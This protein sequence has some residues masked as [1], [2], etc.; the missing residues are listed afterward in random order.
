[1]LSLDPA[2]MSFGKKTHNNTPPDNLAT[3]VEHYSTQIHQLH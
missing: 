2:R 3:K 1:M